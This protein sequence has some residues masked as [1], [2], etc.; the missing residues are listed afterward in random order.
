MGNLHISL[1]AE[2]LFHL[3]PIPITNSFLVMVIVMVLLLIVFSLGARR[4]TMDPTAGGRFGAFCEVIVEYLYNLVVTTGGKKLGR[5]IFPLISALFIFIITSNFTGLLPG[6]GSIT[7]TPKEETHAAA[8]VEADAPPSAEATAAAAAVHD[9]GAGDA[10]VAEPA[11]AEGEHGEV[12]ALLRPPTAD[13]NMTLALSTLTFTVVQIMGVRAHGVGGRLKHMA[14]PFFMFPIEV[15]SEL[16]RI[17]SLAARLFGNVFAGE[18]LLG[19]AYAIANA[20]KI[21]IVPLLFPVMFLG[22]ETIFGTIQALVFALLTLIYI[23]LAA[24]DSHDAH[25]DHHQPVPAE[26]TSLDD[27][28]AAFTGD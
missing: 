9:E 14:S 25:E 17:I 21:A 16:S 20:V 7:V 26:H 27:V 4:I 3:G 13:L 11:A 24:G 5:S 1:S 18:V 23:Y 19:V 10:A 12:K 22:L 28:T 15:V 8:D 6:I 2:T